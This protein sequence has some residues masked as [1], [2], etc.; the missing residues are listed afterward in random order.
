MVDAREGDDEVAQ[1]GEVVCGQA[2]GRSQVRAREEK[3]NERH[4]HPGRRPSPG[5]SSRSCSRN[6]R[7]GRTLS[8]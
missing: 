5:R 1:R 2:A 3:E 7:R 8:G 4:T 6:Y